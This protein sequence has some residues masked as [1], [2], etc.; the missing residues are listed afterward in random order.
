M[1]GIQISGLASGI[2]WNSIISELITADSAGIDQV[3]TQQTTVNT[4]I[5]ALGSLST[6]LTN[7][8]SS[9]FSLEDPSL[10]S[11][12]TAS[13]TTTGSSWAVTAADG[14]PL[15]NY[16]VNVSTLATASQLQGTQGISSPLSSTSNVA[17][18]TIA[19]L[20]TAEAITAGT[21]TVNGQQVTVTTAES[22]QD[23]FDAIST[24]TSGAVTAS[25]NP[26]PGS[27]ADEVTLTSSSPIVLGAANDTSN[28]LQ[29][30]KLTGNN[31]TTIT[32]T[33]TLGTLQLGNMIDNADLKTAL[34]GQ[35]S[36]GNGS[37][38][39]NGVTIDYNT[40]TDSL[41]TVLDTINSS[42]AG[43]TASYDAN[44][45]QIVLTNNSTGDTGITATDISGNLLSA[46]GVASG[47][48]VAGVN[49]Q[50]SVNDGPTQISQSNT[51]SSNALGITGLSVTANTTGT[52][53]IS[54]A[55]D[56]SAI[57]TAIQSFITDFNQL[58]TDISNDTTINTSSGTAV[59]SI[60]SSD[61]EVGDWA[62]TLQSAAFSAG[63]G[64]SGTIK[65]LDDLGI[66]FNGTTGQLSITSSATLQ[67]ALTQSP[68]AV[69]AFF[70]TAQTG[71][72]SIMSST[73][74]DI[75]S[76]NTS[77]TQT[78]QGQS[79]DLSDQI[80]TMQTQLDAEQSQLE[81]EF[82]AMETML[83]QMQSESSTLSSMYSGTTSTTS[84]SNLST[85]VND[86]AANDSSTTSSGSTASTST[87]TTSSSS[88]SS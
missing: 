51:L 83:A 73:I 5:S 62:T 44:D 55:S 6:D 84:S 64:L 25:Y 66:D 49:A 28:I 16:S 30:L 54:V 31:A 88:G 15:G 37:F 40:E 85:A 46:L 45:D 53:T 9:V 65:S 33:A 58:Q 41:N 67:N 79:S 23:V 14:T 63:S 43:V 10:Y 42:S 3:K 70:Q 29:A 68:A 52:Q 38:S 21:F 36:S 1:S 18:L 60:L 59:T 56:T 78:L 27:G 87:G 20:P 80:T 7:L 11:G 48:L 13:S 8:S 82:Q 32:S 72:G 50:F 77:E 81:T 75:I 4:Q 12:V 24:A 57:T 61:D 86:A 17:D 35:D 69:A 26:G 34:T 19:S 2:N 76:Q 47:T 71:F 22:L 74:N 39:I